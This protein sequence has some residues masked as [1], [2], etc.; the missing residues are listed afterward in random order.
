MKHGCFFA[1]ND[2]NISGAFHESL[3]TCDCVTTM[4]CGFD[5]DFAIRKK[6]KTS[7]FNDKRTP[8]RFA[9]EFNNKI[10]EEYV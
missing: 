8:E 10:Y 1:R 4:L 9:K 7:H 3:R 5:A 6:N 2:Q